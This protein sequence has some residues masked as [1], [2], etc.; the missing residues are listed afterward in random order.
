MMNYY[1]YFYMKY[2]SV[3]ISQHITILYGMQLLRT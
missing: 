3:G 2:L 1:T